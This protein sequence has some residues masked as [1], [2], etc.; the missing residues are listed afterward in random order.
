MTAA[1]AFRSCFLRSR[2]RA[3]APRDV[4]RRRVVGKAPALFAIGDVGGEQRVQLADAMRVRG[5]IAN[6]HLRDRADEAGKLPLNR[7]ERRVVPCWRCRRHMVA[8]REVE[9]REIGG[10]HLDTRG[11]GYHAAQCGMKFPRVLEAPVGLFREGGHDERV[12]PRWQRLRRDGRWQPRRL[13]ADP[14]RN[15]FRRP[16]ERALACKKLVEDD[17]GAEQVGPVVARQPLALLGRHVRRRTQHHAGLREACGIDARDA[18]IGDLDLAARR[19]DQVR[20]LDIAVDHAAF[21]CDVERQQQLRDDR[22]DV[23]QVETGLAVEVRAEPRPLDIFHRDEGD[24]F[25]LAILV[26]ADD[27]GVVEAARGARLV[28]EPTNELGSQIGVDE[29]HADRLDRD[30]ALDVR[31]ERFVDDPH[32]ALAEDTLDFVLAEFFGFAHRSLLSTAG[33]RAQLSS[34]FNACTFLGWR[35]TTSS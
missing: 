20:G 1:R 31:V 11:V 22:D 13:V 21:V 23:R 12:D 10:R 30:G 35:L 6:E 14:V 8:Q 25:V 24:V 34:I 26:D 15:H 28:L 17:A 7:G 3:C 19:Q 32:C 2:R 18:E 33:V 4:V 16:G 29:V 27:V 5:R 9:K